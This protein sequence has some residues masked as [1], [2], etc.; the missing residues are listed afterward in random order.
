MNSVLIILGSLFLIYLV[1]SIVELTAIYRFNL[2]FFNY[3]FKIHEERITYKHLKWNNLEDI[4]VENEGQYVFIP[5]TTVGYFVTNF[6]FQ[7]V[8]SLFASYRGIPLV[9]Y[10]KINN[11]K[12]EIVVS[13]HISYRV[14]SVIVLWFLL[15]IVA[16]VASW[17]L[18]GLGVGV[19]AIL[20]SIGFLY[21][22]RFF[23]LNKI[24]RIVDEISG[25]LNLRN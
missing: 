23:Q 8:Y 10:G 17:T 21:L 9:L 18:I 6:Y 22:I 14:V 15:L 5:Q 25:I 20:F 24:I 3:G 11:Q 16:S 19:F 13:F 7:R 12:G 4:Y 2:K 1:L